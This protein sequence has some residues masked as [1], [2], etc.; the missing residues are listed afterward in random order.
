MRPAAAEQS[1]SAFLGPGNT[2]PIA[3]DSDHGTVPEILLMLGKEHIH[4]GNTRFGGD[5]RQPD[6]SRVSLARG[7]DQLPE[8]LIHRNKDPLLGICPHQED[9]VSRIGSPLLGFYDIVPPLTKPV[10][11][12]SAGTSVDQESHLTATWTASRESFA[13]TA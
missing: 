12:P 1:R 5:I 11:Q 10:R 4:E 3:L 2:D 13:M 7:E 8:V 9:S 6:H